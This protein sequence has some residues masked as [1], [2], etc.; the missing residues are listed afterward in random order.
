[1]ALQ[2]A[3]LRRRIAI[4]PGPL[5]SAGKRFGSFLRLSCGVPWSPRVSDGIDTLGALVAAALARPRR[6]P[7]AAAL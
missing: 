3:A 7:R 1:M 2:A 5:F 4:A 6:A